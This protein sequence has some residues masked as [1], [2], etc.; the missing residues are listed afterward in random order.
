M[1]KEI[2]KTKV[3]T[4]IFL[5]IFWLLGSYP[6]IT[7]EISAGIYYAT[8]SYV[9]LLG[10]TALL[11]L[12]LWMLRNKA[13]IFFVATFAILIVV[14]NK[15]NSD[16]L[17]VLLNG[18]RQYFSFLF[19][20][21]ILRYLMATP[22]R[23]VYFIK[24]FEK[25]L[26]AFL[27]LQAPCMVIQCALYGAHDQVGGSLGWMMSGVI[28]TSIYIISFYFI[29]RRWNN[30]ESIIKNVCKNWVLIALLI[31]SYLNETKV[32]F[33]FLLLYFV[34][35]IPMYKRFIRMIIVTAPIMIIT[36][37]LVA[38]IYSVATKTGTEV[39]SKE[40]IEFYTVG[41]EAAQDMV[42]DYYLDSQGINDVEGDDFARG[43]K[44]MATPV[45]MDDRPNAWLV[46]Y[47]VGQFKGGTQTKQTAFAKKY[48]WLLQGTVMSGMMWLMEIGILGCAW[49]LIYFTYLFRLAKRVKKRE[50]RLQW[51]TGLIF[52][53]IVLYANNFTCVPFSII[54]IY[55][56]YVSS[57]WNIFKLLKEDEK[58][59][60]NFKTS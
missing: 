33:I 15:I 9:S 25:H 1:E 28:S 16:G 41:D 27:C 14:S 13:D 38:Y 59:K 21:P 47:G 2:S 39:F 7:Q 32:S 23:A 29:M 53:I 49:I 19:V 58:P 12:G 18:S 20:V 35:I 24:T 50:L 48:H 31:P 4:W 46:G 22:D 44:F 8:W 60:L 3:V 11:L 10:E 36:L 5:S 26:Y 30:D 54:F 37:G 34:F 43:L 51:F 52:F 40:Y 55:V 45:V 6:F 56:A 17:T 42:M 57:R